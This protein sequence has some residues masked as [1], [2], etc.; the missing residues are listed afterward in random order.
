[1]NR[2]LL[3][4]ILLI[5]NTFAVAEVP[6]QYEQ[7]AQKYFMYSIERLKNSEE[8]L[9]RLSRKLEAGQHEAAKEDYVKAH[10]QYESVRPLILLFPNL[11]TLL[12]T[13]P[14]DVSNKQLE[15]QNFI[16]FNAVEYE[17]YVHNDSARAF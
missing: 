12:D 14:I 6:A 9:E 8:I 16:G 7:A 17:L 4:L 1:M 2:I 15:I 13:H 5:A 10:Y 11:N 3:C